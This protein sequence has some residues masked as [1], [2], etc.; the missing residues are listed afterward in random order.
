MT[1]LTPNSVCSRQGEEEEPVGMEE[2][3]GGEVSFS[4]PC[5]V[6]ATVNDCFN[7]EFYLQS[8]GGGGAA[9]QCNYWA[10]WSRGKL[11]GFSGFIVQEELLNL[12][13]V[14]QQG[15]SPEEGTMTG[16]MSGLGEVAEIRNK[17]S[18]NLTKYGWYE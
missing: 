1:A 4:V 8:S 6:I 16:T 2:V 15:L 5:C 9:S 14:V 18:S 7:T 3:D 17:V 10:G 11:D 12:C 13:V